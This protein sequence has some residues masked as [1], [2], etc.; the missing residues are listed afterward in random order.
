MATSPLRNKSIGKLLSAL[1]FPC[2]KLAREIKCGYKRFAS[3]PAVDIDYR[4]AAEYPAM[5]MMRQPFLRR[6]W[7]AMALALPA[8]Y[9]K[10]N[11]TS[12]YN[13]FCTRQS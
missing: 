4:L 12:I 6:K 7:Q 11:F 5:V 8:F 10:N 9:R 2:E 3:S 1:F 13:H